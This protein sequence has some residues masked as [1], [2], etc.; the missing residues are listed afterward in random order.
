MLFMQV[1]AHSKPNGYISHVGSVK[2][3]KLDVSAQLD[4]LRDMKQGWLDGE[5]APPSHSGLD[6]LSNAFKMYYP[7]GAGIP[8]TYPTPNGGVQMEWSI[9]KREISPRD[10]SCKSSRRMELL[11]R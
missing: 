11:R 5:G 9:N 2:A 4:K 1:T 8:Y 10:R 3:N 6:W 7:D